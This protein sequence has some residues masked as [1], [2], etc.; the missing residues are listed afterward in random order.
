MKIL[1][2]ETIMQ[3]RLCAPYINHDI[4]IQFS[5]LLWS[6]VSTCLLTALPSFWLSEI[7]Q[8]KIKITILQ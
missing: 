4:Y 7:R 2:V 1:H 8:K 6:Q 5:V 3:Y